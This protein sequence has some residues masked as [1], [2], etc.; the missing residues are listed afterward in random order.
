[1]KTK[2]TV[3]GMSCAACSAR[4]EKAVKALDGVTDATVN[5]LTGSLQVEGSVAPQAVC[6]AVVR[7]GYGASALGDAPPPTGENDTGEK[8]RRR[9]T[10]VRFF[11]SLGLL[12]P[13]MYL[14]MG[15]MLSL[16]AIPLLRE[17]PAIAALAQML[18]SAAVLILNG[19]FFVRGVKG[20]LHRA[21][22]MD[23]LVSLGSGA[24]FLYSTGVLFLMLYALGKGDAAHAS[25]LLHNLYFESAAMILVLIS[26]GKALEAR[27]KGKTTSAIR[28]L[29][30]L[31]PEQTTVLREGAPLV[32]P[33][34]DVRVGDTVVLRPGERVSVDGVILSGEGA[35]DES[36]LSGESLPV[37]KKAGD[38]VFSATVNLSGAILYRATGVGEDTVLGRIVATVREASATKAPIAKLAD[39]V[40]GVFVPVVTGLSLLTFILW[41][42]IGGELSVAVNHAISVLVISCPC[43]LG[44]ATP[45]AVMVGSGKGAKSGILFK[46]A[47]ALENAGRIRTVFLDKTGTVTEGRPVVTDLFP[48]DG[49][50]EQTLLLL[51]ASLEAGSEHPLGRAVCAY[52]KERG[53]SPLPVTDFRADAGAGVR[54][55]LDG[56]HLRGGKADYLDAP[57]DGALAARLAREGKTPLFFARDGVP[58]GTVAVADAVR[59][60]S[61]DAV[62]YLKSHGIRTVLLTGDRRDVADAVARSVGIDEVIPEAT[63]EGKADAV[64]AARAQG[65]VMMVGD[66]INDAPALTA[67]DVGAAVGAGTDIAIDSA[68]LVLSRE[69]L[70]GL[71]D[72]VALSRAVMRNIK[73]NLFWAFF[74]NLLGIPLAAGVFVPLLGWTLSPMVGAAAMSLSSLCVVSNALRLGA[75]RLP[76]AARPEREMHK[77]QDKNERKT[78]KMQ[79]KLNI[80]GMMCPHCEG[81][82]RDALL[83]T[84]G[85]ESAAVSHK[86]GTATVTHDGRTNA[87]ALAAVVTGAGYKVTSTT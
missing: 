21:P 50:S 43:A 45:V 87:E 30:S 12:L 2:Y 24:S 23:T 84:E 15:G 49:V 58:L 80:E 76:F 25:H 83:A 74:Y 8:G 5:L 78:V 64:R 63:P 56:A 16:P 40:S 75:V 61:A 60:D 28:E 9:A 20:V 39:R 11:V 53:V 14:S 55:V 54:A 34:R 59:A 38:R 71:A 29:L 33:T 31:A 22:N 42:A 70:T 77:N 47:T 81:R 3:T 72:A 36:A 57:V 35:F 41:W 44:L 68:E 7:A 51:A 32:I 37:D 19:G 13:L 17:N 66:G 26:L 48:A 86:D 52:A 10:L 46:T 73:Q 4:V 82:V 1:M 18:L 85:V 62:A 6:D 79:T 67:A 27:A 69:G 65:M